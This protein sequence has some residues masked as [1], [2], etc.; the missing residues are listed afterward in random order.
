MENEPVYRVTNTEPPSAT[1]QF[2]N[3]TD[4]IIHAKKLIT[5]NPTKYDAGLYIVKAVKLVSFESPPIV[6]TEI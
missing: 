6:V 1:S 5:K 2:D 3:E 4:A